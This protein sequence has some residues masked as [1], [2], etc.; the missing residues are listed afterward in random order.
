MYSSILRQ[1][2]GNLKNQGQLENANAFGEAHYAPC[3]DVFKLSLRVEG[4]RVV[5]A[6]FEAQACGPV[7][8][9]GSLATEELH[10][11]SIEEILKRD[12]F[13]WDKAAGGLPPAKRHAI[14]LL[15]EALHQALGVEPITEGI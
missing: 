2:A 1:H 5:A 8:A 4:D 11:L 3:G 15:L 12:S 14:L 7:K 6:S 10:G 9:F 13:Y